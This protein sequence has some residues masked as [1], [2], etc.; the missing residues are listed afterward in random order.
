MIYNQPVLFFAKCVILFCMKNPQTHNRKPGWLK[1]RYR[2]TETSQRVKKLIKHLNLH[3]VCSSARCPNAGECWSHGTA[4]FMIL[5]N[6]CTRN[7]HFCGV[8]TGTPQ[9][10]DPDEPEHVAIAVR[11]LN[12][13]HSVITSVTRDDLPDGGASIFA[14]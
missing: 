9:N 5:G 6:I 7:C 14:E 10:C 12:L 2:N 4:T 13:R 3:T 1:V 11:K 8:Q